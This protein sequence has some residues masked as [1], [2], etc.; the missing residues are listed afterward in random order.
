MYLNH[1][2]LIWRLCLNERSIHLVIQKSNIFHL[3][4]AHKPLGCVFVHWFDH[5]G[6]STE[7]DSEELVCS[8][9]ELGPEGCSQELGSG[10][11]E[12]LGRG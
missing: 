11:L 4:V 5:A 7:A 2:K 10:G 1:R 9:Q 6:S 12:R 8:L 3:G